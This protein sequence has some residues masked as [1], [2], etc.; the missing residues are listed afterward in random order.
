[1]L[2]GRSGTSE[3]GGGEVVDVRAPPFANER[4]VSSLVKISSAVSL[5]PAWK[6]RLVADAPPISMRMCLGLSIL[7]D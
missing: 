1:M 5:E 4:D 7:Q 2:R 6:C 3:T